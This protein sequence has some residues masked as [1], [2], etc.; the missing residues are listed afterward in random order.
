MCA[1]AGR[2]RE[3]LGRDGDV[4]RLRGL[5]APSAFRDWCRER[6]CYSHTHTKVKPSEVLDQLTSVHICQM[7]KMLSQLERLETRGGALW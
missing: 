6:S 1:L 4:Y 5:T 3:M 2:P 7:L